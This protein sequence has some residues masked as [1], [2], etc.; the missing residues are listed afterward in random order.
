MN[1]IN[2]FKKEGSK[3]RV[4][5]QPNYGSEGQGFKYQW[6]HKQISLGNHYR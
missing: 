1:V 4:D 5:S 3:G 2:Q 6:R